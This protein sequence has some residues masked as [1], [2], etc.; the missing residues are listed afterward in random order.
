M[1][2]CL[3]HSHAD[4]FRL[5]WTLCA[6]Q[7]THCIDQNGATQSHIYAVHTF[8][9]LYEKGLILIIQGRLLAK[10]SKTS[11]EETH[12]SDWPLALKHSQPHS[13]QLQTPESACRGSPTHL[14]WGFVNYANGNTLTLPLKFDIV[15]DGNTGLN[16][17]RFKS[18]SIY[19]RHLIKSFLKV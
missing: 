10:T 3:N 7:R 14:L 5:F 12:Q 16:W 8:L 18:L 4:D 2:I 11:G 15:P 19:F 1:S 17:S 9:W 13:T 6:H